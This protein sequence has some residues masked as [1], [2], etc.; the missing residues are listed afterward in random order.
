MTTEED[1]GT[2]DLVDAALRD[3]IELVSDLVVAASSTER[4][5]TPKEVDALLGV[6]DEPAGESAD[7]VADESS[8]EPA[9]ESAGGPVR[10]REDE[11]GEGPV[12]K[13]AQPQG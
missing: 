4:H 2:G 3:E 10:A 1:E 8:E 13:R 9:D 11:S 6:E 5:F 7:E 12:A